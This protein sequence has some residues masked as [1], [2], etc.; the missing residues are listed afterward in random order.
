MED[1]V[2]TGTLETS[3][4]EEA[5]FSSFDIFLFSL[6]VGLLIYWWFFRQK[7]EEVPEFKKLTTE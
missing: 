6:I 3:G 2:A 5:L 7:K 4:E 1:P